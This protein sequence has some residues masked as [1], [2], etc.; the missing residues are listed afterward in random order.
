LL[1][2]MLQWYISPGQTV[3]EHL[4]GRST[5][6]ETNNLYLDGVAGGVTTLATDYASPAPV[7]CCLR[8]QLSGFNYERD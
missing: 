5:D 8:Y 1:N 6:Y 7:T 3:S 4:A 2:N